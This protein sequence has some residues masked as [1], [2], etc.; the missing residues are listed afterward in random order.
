M[1]ASKINGN[2]QEAVQTLAE[3]FF[4]QGATQVFMAHCC[5]RIFAGLTNPVK[6]RVCERSP[7]SAAFSSLA[8]VNYEMIPE[9]PERVPDAV[10]DDPSDAQS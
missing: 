9:Q 6:C 5:Q 10:P 4:K 7:A 8:E 3:P 1:D 2:P